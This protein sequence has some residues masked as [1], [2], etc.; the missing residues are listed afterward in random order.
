MNEK[1]A[2]EVLAKVIQ[3]DGSLRSMDWYIDW[4]PGHQTVSLDGNFSARALEA[5]AWWIRE[6]EKSPPR[7]ST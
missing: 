4:T 3:P 7:E 5:V 6:N 2:R 1:T